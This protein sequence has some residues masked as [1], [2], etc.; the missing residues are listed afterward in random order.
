LRNFEGKERSLGEGLSLISNHKT[1]ALVLTTSYNKSTLRQQTNNVDFFS[2]VPQAQKRKRGESSE[3]DN[4][5]L[6][7]CA[8]KS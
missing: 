4:I 1:A 2:R 8:E 7:K 5:K 6:I 3:A